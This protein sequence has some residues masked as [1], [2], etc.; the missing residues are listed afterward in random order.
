MSTTEAHMTGA[1]HSGSM[2]ID[3]ERQVPPIRTSMSRDNNPRSANTDTSL[4]TPASGSSHKTAH[5]RYVFAD[6]VAFSYLA[7]DH[8]NTVLARRTV[9]E[10]YEVYIVEQWACSR[11]HPSFTITTFTGDPVH[12]IRVNV[13]GV[14]SNEEAWSPQLK[15]YDK[16]LR[17]Y[18][19]REKVTPLGTLMVTN[20]SGFPSSL[21]MIHVPDGDLYMNKEIF[22]VNENLKRLGCSGRAGLKLTTPTPATQAKFHQL[23]RTSEKVPLNSS[24]IELV[25]L[26]QVAL[27]VFGTLRADYVDGLLCDMTERAIN[28]WWIKLGTEYYNMEPSDGML[29]PST[30]AGLLGMLMGARNRLHAY[31]APVPKDVFDVES[32]KRG[33]A[34]FQKSQR[35]DK[36]RRLDHNTLERLQRAT[37]KAA[38]GEGWAMPRAVKSTVAELSGKG[39]EMVMEMVGARDKPGISEIE[40]VDIDTFVDLVYGERPKWLWH[41]KPR[42]SPGADMFSRLP[43]DEGMAFQKDD[44]G[45][46]KWSNRQRDSAKEDGQDQRHSTEASRPLSR[47]NTG[48]EDEKESTRRAVLRRATGRNIDGRSGFDRIKDVVGGRKHQ[49]KAS[50]DEHNMRHAMDDQEPFETPEAR[51]EESVE[52]TFT[53]VMTETPPPQEYQAPRFMPPAVNPHRDQQPEVGASLPPRDH[54]GSGTVTAESSIAGSMYKGIEL[55]GG[56]Q[57]DQGL[58]DGVGITLRRTQSFIH[59]QIADHGIRHDGWWPRHMSFSLAE[60]SVLT[61]NSLIE[62][63]DD[64]KPSNPTEAMSVEVLKATDARR[65]RAKLKFLAEDVGS[66]VERNL[67]DVRKL[68]EQAYNDQSELEELYYPQLDEYHALRQDTQ[69]VL[70]RERMRLK[71]TTADVEQ[72]GEQLGYEIDQLKSKIED[73][74]DSVGEFERQVRDVESRVMELE[75]LTKEREG[76]THWALRCLI[77]IGKDP[78]LQE[79]VDRPKQ[80]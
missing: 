1:A 69:D 3:S 53:K 40:T 54:G 11:S 71:D 79:D 67:L 13:L 62:F 2:D 60:E 21:S 10:G 19:A 58:H 77:G 32:T 43:G 8:S 50:R 26:C 38:N 64:P 46:Y 25:K 6:P 5:K 78:A 75:E 27:F 48:A 41:G 12:K 57:P 52:P 72:L 4:G 22:V 34:Y 7:D 35:I 36:T 15:I 42:K 63:T 28:D 55:D 59:P 33:I 80:I 20:L 16:A 73:V 14:P 70:T 23:Y 45:E 56:L 37:A 74:E 31:G 65:T 47:A 29:G 61:W 51:V 44:Q 24:V 49:T 30:V 76:W 9:L 17:K 66:W 68:D 39:G 18:H